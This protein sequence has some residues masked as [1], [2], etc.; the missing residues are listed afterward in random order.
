MIH[1][2][3]GRRRWKKDLSADIQPSRAS[4]IT[5]GQMLP[6]GNPVTTSQSGEQQGDASSSAKLAGG[7][8]VHPV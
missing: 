1:L 4:R 2:A 6:L 3:D 8:N 5:D 7:A